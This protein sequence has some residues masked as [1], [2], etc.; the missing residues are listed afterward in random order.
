M[1]DTAHRTALALLVLSGL[2][3]ALAALVGT[4]PDQPLVWHRQ[5]MVALLGIGLVLAA[6]LPALR[7]PVIAAALLVKASA[8]AIGL[9][10]GA[11][12]G[13]TL[14]A[15]ICGLVALLAAGAVFVHEARVEARWNGVLGWRPEV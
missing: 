6:V 12:L 8:L 14:A 13:L 10:S 4:E 9:A 2:G 11:P 1:H 7:L 5:F 3:T 15:E